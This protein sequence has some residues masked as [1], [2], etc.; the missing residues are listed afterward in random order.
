M[1]TA[2]FTDDEHHFRALRI[3]IGPKAGQPCKPADLEALARNN[4][5]GANGFY[6]I[7]LYQTWHNG[8]HLWA[9][10][11]DPVHALCDGRIVAACVGRKTEAHET[12]GCRG[13]VLVRHTLTTVEKPAEADRLK[14]GKLTNVTFFAL[15]QHL[16]GLGRGAKFPPWLESMRLFLAGEAN[17]DEG[18]F[19]KVFGKPEQVKVKGKMKTVVRPIE[20]RSEPTQD[21]SHKTAPEH[22]MPGKKVLKTLAE[23]TVVQ[24]LGQPRGRF[25]QVRVMA[26]ERLEGWLSLDGGTTAELPELGAQIK[27]LRDGGT[28]AI[29]HPVVAGEVLGGGRAPRG[30]PPARQ[31]PRR[32]LRRPPRDLLRAAPRPRVREGLADSRGRHR[33]RRDGGDGP[34]RAEAV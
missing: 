7:G 19:V 15:Y 3:P 30:G 25:Q 14:R 31:W 34:R 29:D 4:E 9:G 32:R 20:L 13:F 5:G 6:P 26:G 8:I 23:A 28:V 10:E 11:G 16:L 17:P 12:F 2:P 24:V 27:A 22:W 33:R 21:K 18:R 1:T